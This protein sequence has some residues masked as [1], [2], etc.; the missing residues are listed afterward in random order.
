VEEVPSKIKEILFSTNGKPIAL[1]RVTIQSYQAGRI[2]NGENTSKEKKRG[3][4]NKL[5]KM[6]K[7]WTL[8]IPSN[9]VTILSGKSLKIASNGYQNSPK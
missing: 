8:P 1:K 5:N 9:H 3:T 2:D 4:T 6:T 7:S